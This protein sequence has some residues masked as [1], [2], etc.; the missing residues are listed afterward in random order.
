MPIVSQ[1]HYDHEPRATTIPTVYRQP[2]QTPMPGLPPINSLGPEIPGKIIRS[3]SAHQRTVVLVEPKVHS[4]DNIHFEP[5]GGDVEIFDEKL[6]FK[7]KAR[8]RVGSMENIHHHPGGGNVHIIDEP[9][10]LE[11][12]RSRIGS[13]SI[14]RASEYGQAYN[15]QSK[16]RSPSSRPQTAPQSPGPIQEQIMQGRLSWTYGI[17]RPTYRSFSATGANRRYSTPAGTRDY[18]LPRTESLLLPNTRHYP[19]QVKDAV[20]KVGSLDNI[21]HR[22]GGGNKKI[23]EEKVPAKLKFKD[24]RSK[25]GSLDNIKH[26]PGGGDVQIL[27]QPLKIKATAK[28]GSK[29]NIHHIPLGGHVTILS[30]PVVY[31][32]KHI[33]RAVH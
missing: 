5:P 21:T 25:V 10:H 15:I 18:E 19:L 7:Q 33:P 1:I 3:Q 17:T 24:V 29:D 27:D 16:S 14:G 32:T 8:S 12:I 2:S 26:I 20:S 13:L 31:K 6:Q 22:R 9:L 30:Q 23:F 28:V 11:K 4:L